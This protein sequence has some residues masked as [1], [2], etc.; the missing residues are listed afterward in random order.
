MET[1]AQ[2]KSD[3]RALGD[4]TVPN[5]CLTATSNGVRWMSV[6]QNNHQQTLGVVGGAIKAVTNFMTT[7][8]QFGWASFEIYDGVNQVGIGRLFREWEGPEG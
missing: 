8:G 7:A 4:V 1:M 3:L 6:N 2:V 5:G